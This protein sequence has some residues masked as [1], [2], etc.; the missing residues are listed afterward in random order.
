[1][2]NKRTGLF[3]TYYG[4]LY[5]ESEPLTQTEME[6]NAKYIYSF[7]N[8]LGWSI[9]AVA[10][11]LGNLQAESSINPGRWQSD[12]VGNT[13]DGYGLVQWTPA[14]KYFDWCKSEGLTDYSA[15]DANLSRID[16]E[17]KN[18]QQWITTESY[19]LSF[20]EFSVSDKS[21]TYLAAA[22]LINYE[23][24]ADQSEAVKVYR[25]ELASAWYS[26]L[27][28]VSPGTPDNPSITTNSKKKKYNFLLFNSKRRMN[29][30]IK[31]PF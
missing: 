16:Y 21:V 3:G 24:P 26:Y 5:T 11:I 17:V 20:K 27:T 15:M 4:S 10:A 13:A 19:N 8:A 30:W 23:R 9:N 25:G 18:N 7:F 31:K 28:G 1:M 14:T 12:I 29:Q 6:A 22:F 2:A